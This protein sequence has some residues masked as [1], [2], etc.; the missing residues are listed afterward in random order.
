MDAFDQTPG[1]GF[2]ELLL[3]RDKPDAALAEGSPDREV[4]R[5]IAGEAVELMDDHHVD[6]GG[7]EDPRQHRLELGPVLRALGSRVPVDVLVDKR[8][9]LVA[10]VL[11]A[12]FALGRQGEAFF[13]EVALGLVLGGDA[14]VDHAA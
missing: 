11:Q 2:L 4:V 10:D 8:P 3:D 1:G 12:G 6:V 5:G 7:L 9:A 13:G 14:Q